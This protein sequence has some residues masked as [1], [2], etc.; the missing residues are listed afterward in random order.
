MKSEN[1]VFWF[2]SLQTKLSICILVTNF[3]LV[4][5]S[6]S[7]VFDAVKVNNR[8]N[9][10]TAINRCSEFFFL[11]IEAL[12]FE[13]GRTNVILSEESPIT[14]ANR[15]FIEERRVQADK[16]L[17]IGLEKLNEIDPVSANLLQSEYAKFLKLRAKADIQAEMK[18]AEREAAFA[19]EWFANSTT[20]IFRIKETL[21][22]L[23]KKEL[24]I[25]DFDF[26]YQLQL[27]CIEFRLFS[28]Y[29]GSVLTAAISRGTTI[30]GEK[31]QKLIESRVKADYIWANIDKDMA[32]MN[33]PALGRK[34]DKVFQEYYNE[35][36]SFQNE[37]LRQALEGKVPKDSVQRLAAL[38]VPAFDS[39]FDLIAEVSAENRNYV[40]QM[41]NKAIRGLEVALLEFFLVLAFSVFSLNYFR[42]M[43]FSPMKRI[44]N[45][46]QSIVNGQPVSNLETDAKRQD[47]IGWLVQGVKMLQVSMEEERRLKAKNEILATTDNL[48]GLYNRHMLD[49]EAECALAQADRYEGPISMIVFDLDHFKNV[50]DTCGHLIG[51]EV[52]KQT[53]QIV[54][55]LIRR[56]DKLFRFGGE[57]F[58]ILMPK[59]TV[60]EAAAVA[61]KIRVVL[62]EN[63]HPYA[64]QVTVSI[65]VAERYRKEF[66]KDF[67]KRADDNLYRAKKYGRNRVVRSI[68][69]AVNMIWN[70]EWESGHPEIDR[71]HQKLL[72]RSKELFEM[73]ML[74]NSESEKVLTMLET[75]IEEIDDHFSSEE[76]ILEQIG[77]PDVEDH[78]L[79]HTQLL[80]KAASLKNYYLQD[81]ISTSSFILFILDDVV[82]GHM[83]KE[84]KLFFPYTQKKT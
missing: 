13:R 37:I 32:E 49:Q 55:K 27:A 2:R 47:E 39:I 36:R 80:T 29:S 19:D 65:G 82:L 23:G 77:Y 40:E 22:V 79:I 69:A 62:E 43:L 52:L 41:K 33:N 68:V 60:D 20:F 71:Q 70:P 58:L 30:P 74:S 57:E 61:E 28:G 73:S 44:I 66:F 51:D 63:K 12:A 24:I 83:L 46:L 34:S 18:F 38:S 25:D 75:L 6:M 72:E 50:N 31:Y 21:A 8:A 56:S 53:A 81:E 59:T 26:Y 35:Y 5:F 78:K 67:Y 3:V 76:Q 84:D 15:L 1:G 42:I 7:L 54:K 14:D 64:G 17:S 11:T 45:A 4:I 48:T 10:I 9:R 16:N